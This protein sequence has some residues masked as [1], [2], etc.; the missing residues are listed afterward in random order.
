MTT[1]KEGETLV[2]IKPDGIKRRLAGEIVHWIER[3]GLKVIA[4]KMLHATCDQI[5]DYYPKN[6]ETVRARRTHAHKRAEEDI[7]F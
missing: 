2:L 6:P 7:M 5:D 4:L 1:F 3:R